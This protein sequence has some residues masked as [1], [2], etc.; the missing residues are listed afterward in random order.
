MP[1]AHD[2]RVIRTVANFAR[3]VIAFL[4]VNWAFQLR[5]SPCHPLIVAGSLNAS[6]PP[7]CTTC[8]LPSAPDT[9]YT[10]L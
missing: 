1:A 9:R 10:S 8:G 7:A 2:R 3:D 6:V 4:S 5:K